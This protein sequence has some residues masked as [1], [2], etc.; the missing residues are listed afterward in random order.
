MEAFEA[1]RTGASCTQI[2]SP[3]TTHVPL[4][5]PALEASWDHCFHIIIGSGPRTCVERTLSWARY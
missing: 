5:S 4:E 1:R 3:I 2:I